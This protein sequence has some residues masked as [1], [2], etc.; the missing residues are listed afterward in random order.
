MTQSYGFDKHLPLT[1]WKVILETLK[2][3]D[4]HIIVK[5]INEDYLDFWIGEI[6]RV[7]NDCVEIH[8][9]DPNGIL[10][11]EPKSISFDTISS[12]NFLDSYSATFR[13]YI[14]QRKKK[15]TNR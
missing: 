11:E 15:T 10:D 14:K 8:N 4:F 6:V 9:Y 13:K 3:Y 7:T 1:N 12:L 2:E 5:N